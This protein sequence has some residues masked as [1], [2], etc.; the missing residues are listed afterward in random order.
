MA[1]LAA[2]GSLKMLELK[3][4]RGL[5]KALKA[6]FLPIAPT[7]KIF[8]N[9]EPV[10]FDVKSLTPPDYD[11]CNKVYWQHL[12]ISPYY[13]SDK[14]NFSRR[15][16]RPDPG[17]EKGYFSYALTDTLNLT[18]LAGRRFTITLLAKI[19][20]M[21]PGFRVLKV[22]PRRGYLKNVKNVFSV[23]GTSNNLIDSVERR[24]TFSGI[25]DEQHRYATW[26]LLL[27]DS[28][29]C[30][31]DSVRFSVTGYNKNISIALKSSPYT[32]RDV[33]NLISVYELKFERADEKS[34]LYQSSLKIGDVLNKEIVPGISVI[35]PLVLYGTDDH[36]FPAAAESSLSTL[37]KKMFDGM[38]KNPDGTVMDSGDVMGIRFANVIM[39]W[40]VV[41]CSY[42]N[43][44]IASKTP[45]SILN[46]G[47]DAAFGDTNKLDFLKSL[48][49]M[50]TPL[51]DNLFEA[52]LNDP[53]MAYNNFFAPIT[54]EEINK[55]VI[56]ISVSGSA[57]SKKI[58]AGD[59]VISIDD[60]PAAEM[61]RN[62]MR[63]ISGS[64]QWKKW[65]TLQ[66]LT[67]GPENSFMQLTVNHN[68]KN[69]NLKLVRDQFGRFNGRIFVNRSDKPSTWV[70]SH[71]Y[72]LNL[73]NDSITAHLNELRSAKAII[74]DLRNNNLA[75]DNRVLNY[76]IKSDMHISLESYPIID[77]TDYQ[78]VKYK[79]VDMY[80]KSK[81]PFTTRILFFITDASTTGALENLV[82]LVKK[83]KL[84]K[85]IGCKTAGAYTGAST[86]ALL[87]D[88]VLSFSGLKVTPLTG[89]NS[90]DGIV[91]DVFINSSKKD[92]SLKT[93]I[94]Y[95]NQLIKYK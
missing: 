72:Y 38:K 51:N 70:G 41:K 55:Q 45:L 95:A 67:S 56:V 17:S 63:L 21:A 69:E 33:S 46:Y 90:H 40:N 15:A 82:L 78:G 2:Y 28:V 59:A 3:N 74:F 4:D 52:Y 18:P 24:L 6:I 87:G 47:L 83:Y 60:K 19:N 7:I 42:V 76:F 1:R 79:P 32:K 61:L 94:D 23:D 37:N 75:Y 9:S 84:G 31:I 73:A 20:K 62:G 93:A 11:L 64:A 48:K 92:K 66:S 22:E 53:G 12:G 88:Y 86:F 85:I 91:P 58:K 44:D 50:Y 65:R 49:L 57:L 14:K 36:T 77:Y 81:C 43:W 10:S 26:K 13:G 39:S 25:I 68:R 5:V 71:I 29:A 80:L 27:T 16:N 35:V 30:L 34:G 89:F 54:L 8:S